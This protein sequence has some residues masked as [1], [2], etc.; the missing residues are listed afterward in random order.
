MTSKCSINRHEIDAH[1][2]HSNT[3]EFSILI[4]WNKLLFDVFIPRAWSHLLE[5]IAIHFQTTPIFSAWPVAKHF[6][7]SDSAY[8]ASFPE[9]VLDTVL[10]NDVAVWPVIGQ[11]VYK[12]LQDVFV[13]RPGTSEEVTQALAGLGMSVC[14]PPEHLFRMIEALPNWEHRILTPE[15]TSDMLRVHHISFHHVFLYLIVLKRSSS[16]QIPSTRQRNGAR[17][18]SNTC[19]RRTTSGT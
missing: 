3:F 1:E 6:T 4:E 7:E 14:R 11:D 17:L 16:L 2:Y 12:Q 13:S 8:W 9:N 15:R 5:T 18:S 19:F 10:A